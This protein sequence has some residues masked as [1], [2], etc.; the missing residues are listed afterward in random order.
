MNFIKYYCF[1]LLSRIG[2]YQNCVHLDSGKINKFFSFSPSLG[3]TPPCR[4]R[5]ENK[6][7]RKKQKIEKKVQH[8]SQKIVFPLAFPGKLG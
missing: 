6:K 4:E 1:I 2:L 5:K 7:R 3:E 8:N